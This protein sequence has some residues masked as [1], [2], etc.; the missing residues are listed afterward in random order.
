M[1]DRNQLLND[2]EQ[3]LR[4]A[5]DGMLSGVWTNFPGIIQSVNF[6]K[7]TCEVVPAI[8]GVIEDENG[9]KTFVSLPVLVDVPI[10]FPSSKGFIIT[11]PLEAGDEVEVTIASRCIDAWWQ[12]GGIQKPMEARM[13]DLSDG[14]AYPGLRSLPNVAP[15]ISSTDIQIRNNSGTAYVSITPAGKVNVISASE[16]DITAPLVKVT[17]TLQVVGSITATAIQAAEVTVGAI[18]LSAH[19]HTGVSTGAGMSGGPV[20]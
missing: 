9:V 11:F 4:I 7:M 12:S 13:H 6:S 14:F 2:P 15:A 5:F 10:K 17:G 3:A 1:A 20:P 19:K 18:P 8:Q 16:V